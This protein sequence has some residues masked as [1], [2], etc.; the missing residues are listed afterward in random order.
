MRDGRVA[1]RRVGAQERVQ[2]EELTVLLVL[3]N[4]V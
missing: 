2:V 1:T 4:R 3:P